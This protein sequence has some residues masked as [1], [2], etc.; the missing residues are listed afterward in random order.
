MYPVS[1]WKPASPTPIVLAFGA[2]HVIATVIFLNWYVTLGALMCTYR[3]CPSRV[4]LIHRLFTWLPFVPWY[5]TLKAYIFF[6][7]STSDLLLPFLTCLYYLFTSRVGTEFFIIRFTYFVIQQKSLEL[8]IRVR[9][10]QFPQILRVD[11]RFALNIGTFN[12]LDFTRNVNVKVEV[13]LEAN[14]AKVVTALL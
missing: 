11:F 9:I 3:W 14:F 8:S 1:H 5:L 13:I 4:Y 12:F 10:Y 2:W 6:T 7:V